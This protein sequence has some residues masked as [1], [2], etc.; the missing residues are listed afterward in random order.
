MNRKH[1]L[2][3]IANENNTSLYQ[4]AKVS[5]IP[6][7]TLYK[8]VERNTPFKNITI[9]TMNKIAQGLNLSAYDFINKYFN[10]YYK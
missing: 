4:I 1:W 2:Y 7:S 5:E 3:Q 6:E 10:K 9:S 8:I